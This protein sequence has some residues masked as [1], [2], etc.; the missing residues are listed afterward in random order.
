MSHLIVQLSKYLFLL[1]I[2]FYVYASFLYSGQKNKSRQNAIALWQLFLI[3]LFQGLAYL[4]IFEQNGDST[5]WVFYEQVGRWA[6][7]VFYAAQVIFLVVYQVVFRIFYRDA[8]RLLL[9]H[10]CM[11]LTIGLVIQ[12][13]LSPAKAWNQFVIACLSAAVTLVVP[14]VMKY[15]RRI[16]RIRWFFG[17]FGIVALGITF[18][19]AQTEYGAKLSV[20]IGNISVQLTEIVKVSFVFFVAASFQK[21]TGF[22]QI[23]ITTVVAALHVLV[24]V[25]CKDLGAALILFLSY[26]FMLFVATRNGWYFLAGLGSGAAA[27]ALAYKLFAHVRIRVATWRDPWSD[28]TD[29]GWQIAQSLFAIGAGGWFGVGLYEGIPGSIPIVLKDFIFAAVCEEMGG[30]FAIGLLLIFLSCL[31]QFMWTATSMTEP[32]HKIVCFGLAC[33]MA[34]QILLNIGGVTKFIPLTGVTLPLISYGGS[35]VFST[36]LL[37]NVVQGSILMRQNEEKKVEKIGKSETRQS[38]NGKTNN[39]KISSGRAETDKPEHSRTNGGKTGR[40]KTGAGK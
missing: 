3:F 37:F 40:Q 38:E 5:K 21:S 18:L 9:N 1:L 17:L 25:A 27:C 34:I 11:L 7:W 20:T 4:V 33:V 19:T 15:W 23:A 2:L 6:L 16:Y 10:L 8:S 24:L 30:L 28:I 32:F 36:F 13:R 22:K 35:S 31:L 12:T 29:S 39:G 26:I 14:M